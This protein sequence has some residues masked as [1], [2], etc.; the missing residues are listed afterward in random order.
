MHPPIEL[1]KSTHTFPETYIF[2][3]IGTSDEGF[4]GRVLAS[5]RE[6]AGLQTDPEFSVRQTTGGRHVSVTLA[7]PMES[8]ERVV[9][10]YKSLAKVEGLTL[11]L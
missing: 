2:K 5:A 7:L 6:A 8:A 11:L 9:E 1:L 10:V 3:V 4:L